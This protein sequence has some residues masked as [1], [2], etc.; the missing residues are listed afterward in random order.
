MATFEEHGINDNCDYGYEFDFFEN[1][2]INLPFNRQLLITMQLDR[3]HP[4][5]YIQRGVSA[6]LVNSGDM[7]DVYDAM[8]LAV[9]NRYNVPGRFYV[10]AVGKPFSQWNTTSDVQTAASTYFNQRAVK[11]FTSDADESAGQSAQIYDNNPAAFVALEKALGQGTLER[12]QEYYSLYAGS[13]LVQDPGNQKMRQGLQSPANALAFLKDSSMDGGRYSHNPYWN[14]SLYNS[15][16]NT[17]INQY[18]RGSANAH[19]RIYELEAQIWLARNAMNHTGTGRKIMAYNEG[20][21]NEFTRYTAF[22]KRTL[23]GGGY[24]LRGQWPPIDFGYLMHQHFVTYLDIDVTTHFAPLT[25][26]GGDKNIIKN[27]ETNFSGANIFHYEPN[28]SGHNPQRREPVGMADRG[29]RPSS[30]TDRPIGFIN[31]MGVAAKWVEKA[32][33]A[34]GTLAWK[35]P[36]LTFNG[37]TYTPGAG[38][39]FLSTIYDNKLPYARGYRNANGKGWM[40]FMYNGGKAPVNVTANLDGVIKTVRLL[41]GQPKFLTFS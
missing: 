26:F 22:Y 34:A 28:G 39:T 21:D 5:W 19:A 16:V 8:G 17:I 3:R 13:V 4:N 29:T 6:V 37:Q 32:Y 14:E 41:P 35:R 36:T 27:E 15:P 38:D 40:E 23:P 9:A 30:Y 12:G 20:V 2:S 24:V 33:A 18:Y 1:N 7:N 31:S 25:L 10:D 11:F